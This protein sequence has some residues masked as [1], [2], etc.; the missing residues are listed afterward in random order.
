MG[1]SG[2]L[3]EIATILGG[4]PGNEEGKNARKKPGRITRKSRIW[5]EA[6]KAD[7]NKKQEKN[8]D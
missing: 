6:G 2:F 4:Y 7:E 1:N 5:L 3:G 8:G